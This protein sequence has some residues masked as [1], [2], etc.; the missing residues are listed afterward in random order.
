MFMKNKPPR[1]TRSYPQIRALFLSQSWKSAFRSVIA[2]QGHVLGWY[3]NITF[4]LC[5]IVTS[6]GLEESQKDS[7]VAL[8]SDQIG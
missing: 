5:G 6:S 3:S 4:E 8:S 1:L 7:F 2:H